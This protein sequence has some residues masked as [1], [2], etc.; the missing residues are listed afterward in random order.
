MN[1]LAESQEML[2]TIVMNDLPSL[3][4]TV[5]RAVIAPAE[6]FTTQVTSVCSTGHHRFI[7]HTLSPPDQSRECVK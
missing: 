2:R 7:P 3:N 4:N 1:I 5:E 6:A